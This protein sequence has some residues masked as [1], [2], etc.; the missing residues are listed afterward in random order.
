M[1][2]FSFGGSRSTSETVGNASSLDVSR[3]G[4]VSGGSSEA[5][6]LA[7]SRDRIAFED[8]FAQLFGGASG[9][10][11]GLDP[12]ML[13]DTADQLFTG[14]LAFLDQLGGGEGAGYLSDRLSGQSPVLDEQIAALSDDVGRFFSEEL[15]T[16]IQSEAVAGGGLGGG[17]QGVAE[18]LAA[19]TA[20]REFSR[21]AT[22]LR[23]ADIDARDRAAVALGDQQNQGAAIGLGSL[24]SLFGIADAGFAAELAPYER[25]GAILGGPTTLTD[26]DSSSFSTAEDFARA[27]ASSFGQSQSSTRST[28][29]GRAVRFGFGR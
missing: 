13:T 23:A 12:S 4:S 21:G 29:S 1:G 19:E 28:S 11:Q 18:G 17:R 26:S 15:L 5:G 16:S 22:A 25:L 9:A 27:F 6:S 24:G 20:A 7:A 3:S 10:A 2:L 8:V 14:G